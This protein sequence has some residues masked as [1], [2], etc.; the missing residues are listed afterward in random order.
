MAQALR[1]LGVEFAE[2]D[3]DSN[4]GLDELYGEHVPVLVD[5][6]GNEIC[7]YRLDPEAIRKLR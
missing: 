7:R 2:I 1:S 4:P 5:A 3:V 6:Q